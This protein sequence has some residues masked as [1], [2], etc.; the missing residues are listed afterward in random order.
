MLRNPPEQNAQKLYLSFNNYE[1]HY[2]NK[3]SST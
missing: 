1:N 2:N 3:F